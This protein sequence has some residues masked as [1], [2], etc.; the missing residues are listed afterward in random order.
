MDNNKIIKIK[1]KVKGIKSL[2]KDEE[3]ITVIGTCLGL[4]P[5]VI[6]PCFCC[7]PA[8]YGGLMGLQEDIR[9]IS[10][11]VARCMDLI[12]APFYR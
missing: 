4:V 7:F 2:F 1:R 8:F 11:F 6:C 10:A 12:F 9:Y 3:A 5:S